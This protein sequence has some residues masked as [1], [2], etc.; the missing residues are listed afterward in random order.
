[1]GKKK[2]KVFF[3]NA[4]WTKI[5]NSHDAHESFERAYSVCL[6]LIDEY[7]FHECS[8]RGF[9][10]GVFVTDQDGNCHFDQSARYREMIKEQKNGDTTMSTFKWC[11]RFQIGWNINKGGKTIF[12]GWK[13]FNIGQLYFLFNNK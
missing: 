2:S 8:I 3:S 13:Q 5:P 10:T 1:M 12:S 9:C 11:L 6:R 7:E 4:S